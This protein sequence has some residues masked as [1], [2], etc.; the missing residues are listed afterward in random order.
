MAATSI[1]APPNRTETSRS[2]M[3]MNSADRNLIESVL[4]H[5]PAHL[6]QRG[7]L[8]AFSG[9]LDS[10]VLL[11]LLARLRDAG[12]IA[13]FT[14]VHVHHGLQAQADRW[15]EHA[16]KITQAHQVPLIVE[17]VE[18]ALMSG[19]LGLEAAARKARYQALARR[20]E[21]G[22]VL[23]TA[24]HRDDQAE[25]FLLQLMRGA[26]VRGL[27]SMPALA[28][29][30]RGWHLR[31]LLGLGRGSILAYAR[32]NALTWI[33]DP[34]NADIRHARNLV[35]HEVIP[36]LRRHW[37]E[38]E[39]TLARASHRMAATEGLLNDLG[40]IDL[41]AARRD[42]ADR[43]DAPALARLT[44]TRLQNVVRTWL[45]EL[46]MPLPPEP[47][48]AEIRRMLDARADALPVLRW[49]G[50]E[51]RRWRDGMYAL[52]NRLGPVDPAWSIDWDVS[53][54]L[55]CHELGWRITPHMVTGHGLRLDAIRSGRLRIR[56]RQGGE[57][58]RLV[59][60]T[61]RHSLKK[62]LQTSSI[63]PWER[64]RLP[65]F[66][67]GEHLVQVGDR[68]IDASHAVRGNEPGLMITLRNLP[69]HI[70]RIMDIMLN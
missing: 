55:D 5:I 36:S 11:H 29:F 33:E 10:S 26:G 20:M 23:V 31:P 61:H 48:L 38:A 57:M 8:L 41:E 49:P 39:T 9:G 14:A 40:R 68:W 22:G 51:L 45:I 1:A 30:A 12:Q 42:Q 43:L 24:H 47:R 60:R 3:A 66:Y 7:L 27:A 37:P 19:G 54:P 69:P 34:S 65:F 67:S 18:V 15:V 46:D 70:L 13:P 59:G 32:E 53:I 50:G 63:P 21:E 35:R 56:L 44:D 17:R 2:N 4:S 62:L 28:P 6:R 52:P 58:L 64:D 16:E 25:T